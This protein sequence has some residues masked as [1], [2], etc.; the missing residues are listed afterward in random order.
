VLWI[1][2][3]SRIVQRRKQL[4]YPL[5]D[6]WINKMWCIYIM[7]CYSVMKRSEVLI[8]VT[9]WMY[10]EN[11]MLPVRSQSSKLQD[12]MFYNSISRMR[13]YRGGEK[14]H[15]SCFF[16]CILTVTQHNTSNTRYLKVSPNFGDCRSCMSGN[17]IYIS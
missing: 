2:A 6:E 15:L 10:L 11:I 8:H 16:Y 9:G 5:A 14:K 12:P 4:K 3:L 13:G 1:V 17:R 7:D